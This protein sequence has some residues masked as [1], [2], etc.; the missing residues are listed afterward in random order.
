MGVAKDNDYDG[1]MSAMTKIYLKY[2]PY[3]VESEIRIDGVLV[4]SPNKLMFQ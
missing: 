2:N 4:E 3:T 1:R